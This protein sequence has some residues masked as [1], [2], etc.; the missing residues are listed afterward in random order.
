[1]F[2]VNI[3]NTTVITEIYLKLTI[4][5]PGQQ[6]WRRSGIFIVALNRFHILFTYCSGVYIADFKKVNTFF[7][8]T[9]KSCSD[10]PKARS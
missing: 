1:M 5:T 10:L 8:L 2:Q 7:S 4:K 3:T 6:H 9:P